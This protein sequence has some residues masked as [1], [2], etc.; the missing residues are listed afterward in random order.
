MQYK[1]NVMIFILSCIMENFIL[2][3]ITVREALAKTIFSE[4]KMRFFFGLFIFALTVFLNSIGKFNLPYPLRN[5]HL[6]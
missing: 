1:E 5:R 3:L 4:G 2:V 6:H